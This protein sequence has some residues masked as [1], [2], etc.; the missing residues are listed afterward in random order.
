M[1]TKAM[2]TMKTN[3]NPWANLP[4]SSA[5]GDYISQ[6]VST[7]LNPRLRRVFWAKGASHRPALLVDYADR[8]QSGFTLPKFKNIS[9][10]DDRD[11]QCLGIELLDTDM[12]AL[13]YKVCVDI[14]S[15]LQEVP[16]EVAKKTCLLRLE[17]WSTFLRPARSKL[18]PESQKGLIAELMFLEY[19]AMEAHEPNVALDGWSGPDGGKRDFSYGQVFIEVKSK[20]S[21]A[22]P[23]IVISSE[24][25]LNVN[26]SERVFLYVVELNN[27]PVDD[28]NAFCITDV[29]EDVA[30]RFSSPLSIVEFD[31]RLA[32]VG[33]FAEDDYSDTLWT[34]GEC[35]YYE[36]RD[37]FPRIDSLSC[38][39]GV[40]GVS[41]Q[42][43]LE[44]CCNYQIGR[45]EL[46]AAM[47]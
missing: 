24:E 3:E 6:L 1:K 34:L 14:I 13:F 39:P 32:E 7:D 38:A 21:S 30:S 42:I 46:I 43:D 9:I 17:R 8:N 29:V 19:D 11:N 16:E 20:R 37:D 35:D 15:A 2:M 4:N 12:R 44:Y 26:P 25:Q 10:Y 22:N 47:E 33:Y 36:V 23:N 5:A 41:Y 27:A 40:A 31:S 28:E 18:S 45:A